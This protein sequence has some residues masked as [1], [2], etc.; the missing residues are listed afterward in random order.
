MD[1]N[2]SG[3][4]YLAASLSGFSKQS[5]ETVPVGR[6]GGIAFLRTAAATGSPQHS[7]GNLVASLDKVGRRSVVLQRG[8]TFF[9]VFVDFGIEFSITQAAP[10]CWCVL[11]AGIGPGVAVMEV[12]H[13][14]HAGI[15]DFLS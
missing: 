10:C 6:T 2:L 11:V 13:E 12:E 14:G 1:D 7:V 8:E 4:A 9:C 5:D 3:G 15:L